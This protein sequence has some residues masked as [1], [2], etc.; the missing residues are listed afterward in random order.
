MQFK[1][2]FT[3]VFVLRHFVNGLPIETGLQD[4]NRY[5]TP[6]IIGGIEAA[7]GYAPYMA[8]IL[9]GDDFVM[10][11]CG[12]SLVLKNLILTAAHCIDVYQVPGGGLMRTFHG[13]VGSNDFRSGGTTVQFRGYH[14]HPDWNPSN[15]KNDIGMLRLH[16]DV[17][18][19]ASIQLVA[20]NFDYIDDEESSFVTGWGLI[21]TRPS[22]TPFNL[23]ILEVSTLQPQACVDT[24]R[25]ASTIWWPGAP[26]VDPAL[27]ICAVNTDGRRGMGLGRGLCYGDSGSPL[28]SRKTGTQIGIA[29]WVIACELPPGVPDMHA[30]ISPHREYIQSVMELYK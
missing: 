30:R 6:H 3:L 2:L 17:Q 26:V 15:M 13:V 29:S 12:G 24:I 20:M 16:E 7:Q 28:V 11:A 25:A 22:I 4:M 18:L 21:T 9:I 5:F 19:S 10:V 1:V 14:I 27:E 23:Q 8:A